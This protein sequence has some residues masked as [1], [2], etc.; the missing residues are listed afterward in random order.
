MS[1]KKIKESNPQKFLDD[2]KA[3]SSVMVITKV[4]NA[5]L[6]VKKSELKKEAENYK[7]HYYMTTAI[8]RVKRLVM[9]VT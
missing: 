6:T 7:I 1:V 2:L 8:F 9:V 3:A 4:S 5:Y